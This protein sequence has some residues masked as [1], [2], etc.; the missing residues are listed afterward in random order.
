MKPLFTVHAG[1]FIFAETVE[2][3][4]SQL[5]LWMP[6]KDTGV[7]FLVTDADGGNSVSVQVKM[8]RDYR[9]A[10]SKSKFDSEL[11]AAGWFVFNYS[12]LQNSSAYI[13][14]LLLVSHERTQ[15]PIFVNIRPQILLQCLISVHGVKK[16]YHLYPWVLRGNRCIEGRGMK[17]S[18]KANFLA[19]AFDFK[20][21]DLT[22]YLENWDF[23]KLALE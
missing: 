23:L 10:L 18:D 22:E 16:S 12:S 1:E 13:W 8:S 17:Q 3:R 2:K 9:P 20:N 15:K 4:H 5:R 19:G 14:S 21:R 11:T 6:T 7:D